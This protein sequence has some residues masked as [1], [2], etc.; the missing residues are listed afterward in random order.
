MSGLL[1]LASIDYLMSMIYVIPIP[2]NVQGLVRQSFG[3]RGLGWGIRTH[4]GGLEL[5]EL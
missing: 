4:G 1:L 3:Q 2:G 5:D